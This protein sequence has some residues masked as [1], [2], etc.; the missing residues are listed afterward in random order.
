MSS[1]GSS[2]EGV[3]VQSQAIEQM[4]VFIREGTRDAGTN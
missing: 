2:V 4:L 3:E 1:T